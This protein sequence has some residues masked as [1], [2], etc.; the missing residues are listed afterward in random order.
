MKSTSRELFFAG[1][2]LTILLLGGAY[3]YFVY[4]GDFER[5]WLGGQNLVSFA[6]TETSKRIVAVGDLSCSKDEKVS[7]TTCQ[8]PAVASA[9]KSENPDA[10]FLLGDLQYEKGEIEAFEQ[11]FA[12][13]WDELKTKSYH[14]PGNH[15]YQ[16]PKAEGY[17]T[18]WG[19]SDYSKGYYN[20]SIGS[21]DI[22]GLNSNCEEVGGCDIDSEQGKWLA[23]VLA[24]NKQ[25]CS[26]AFWHHPRFTSGKYQRDEEV[27]GLSR[28]FWHLLEADGAD[29]VLN[30]HDHLYERFAKQTTDGIASESDGIRQFTVGT[31]GRSLYSLGET[32][33][34]NHEAGV[35]KSFGFL[36]MELK[37][38]SYSW[39]FKD[40]NGQVLDKGSATCNRNN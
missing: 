15:E 4:L 18:Y 38:T 20:G 7:E 5:Q 17:F 33:I 10:I 16:T 32:V 28:D 30:G 13:I 31:G 9:I 29:V 27:R 2:L 36:A 11:V 25:Q 39:Q 12:P 35:D 19:G 8:F 24:I 3:F 6:P 37:P 26:L 1:I 40:V 34:D 22:I 23:E 14:V 21:W